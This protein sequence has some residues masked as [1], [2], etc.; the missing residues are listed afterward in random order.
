MLT[1]SACSAI[2]RRRCNRYD[3]AGVIAL[4]DPEKFLIL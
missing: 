4:L 1:T 3:A 2:H